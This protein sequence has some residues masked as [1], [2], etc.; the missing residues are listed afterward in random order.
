MSTCICLNCREIIHT[1]GATSTSES[2]DEHVFVEIAKGNII[3]GIE[4]EK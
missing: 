2:N 3:E 1:S 4:A